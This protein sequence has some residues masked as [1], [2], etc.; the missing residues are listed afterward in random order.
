[1]SGNPLRLVFPR[2]GEQMALAF[3][4]HRGEA[5]GL[6]LGQVCEKQLPVSSLA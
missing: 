3:V 5:A 1:M 6:H 2:I 4:G